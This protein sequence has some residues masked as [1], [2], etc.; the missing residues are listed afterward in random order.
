MI[1]KTGIF[2]VTFIASSLSAQSGEQT[3][4]KLETG[5][6]MIL[7]P[8]TGT[9]SP[10]AE[11]ERIPVNTFILTRQ[12]TRLMVFSEVNALECPA[13]AYFWVADVLVKDRNELMHQ[14]V[15]IEAS[16]LP[17]PGNRKR[18]DSVAGLTYGKESP[19]DSTAVEIPFRTERLEAV[20]WFARNS[21]QDAALLTL[22]RAM[23]KFPDLY[24]NPELVELL[25]KLYESQ[26]LWGSLF[27][28][29]R[30][31]MEKPGSPSIASRLK[32]WNDLAR[33]Q[34]T[35]KN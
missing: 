19:T 17:S 7:D 12:S 30:R 14:L 4:V 27:E 1:F 20:R 26:Q 6:A 35:D 31:L 25:F 29:S 8:V 22:K 13:N 33:K 23:V 18:T 10:L 21:R 15:Q 34:L 32:Q 24:R 16:Q 9:W 5:S 2:L 28:E 3:W 11:K